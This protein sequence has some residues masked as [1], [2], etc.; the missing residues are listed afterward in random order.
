M[1]AGMRECHAG[2]PVATACMHPPSS[3][4]PQGLLRL[5]TTQ[6]AGALAGRRMPGRLA[7]RP[8]VAAP[9][10]QRT[11]RGWGERGH[12][13]R[14][15]NDGHFGACGG[16]KPGHPHRGHP[17]P[18]HRRAARCRR[19]AQ[20]RRGCAHPGPGWTPFMGSR[21]EGGRVLLACVCLSRPLALC[22]E[23]VSSQGGF[24]M[25]TRFRCVWAPDLDWGYKTAGVKACQTGPGTGPV[26]PHTL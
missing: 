2:Q 25:R 17:A 19:G 13:Q 4:S 23:V 11:C 8:V 26:V 15:G 14:A 3:T 7:Q 6:H 21:L 16:P 10:E 24:R 22:V 5:S 1:P 9:I 12:G 18:D 20:A